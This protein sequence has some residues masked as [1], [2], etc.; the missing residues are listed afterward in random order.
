MSQRLPSEQYARWVGN[1]R[2]R[3]LR[4][5]SAYFY[6]LPEADMAA[7]LSRGGINNGL[8][9]RIAVSGGANSLQCFWVS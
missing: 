1:D 3:T 7:P 2:N 5:I 8:E 9:E 4:D 6:G